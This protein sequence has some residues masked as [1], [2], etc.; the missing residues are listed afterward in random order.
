MSFRVKRV[1]SLKK[2]K[3]REKCQ[4]RETER[5]R[6]ISNEKRK[7]KEERKGYT[8]PVDVSRDRNEEPRKSSISKFFD[9]REPVH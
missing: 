4:D 1:G 9:K 5:N 2:E 3:E 7:K 8:L 6:N